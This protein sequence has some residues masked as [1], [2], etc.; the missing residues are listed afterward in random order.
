MTVVI[1]LASYWYMCDVR[2]CEILHI[3]RSLSGVQ[4]PDT[5]T[6]LT[7]D[8]KEFVVERLKHDSTDLATHWHLKFVWQALGDWKCWMQAAILTLYVDPRIQSRLSTH[9]SI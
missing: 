5:A 1:A 8:E 4:Y 7:E 6:F 2:N 3:T 9:G